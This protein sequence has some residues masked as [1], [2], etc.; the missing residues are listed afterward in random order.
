MTELVFQW[1]AGP[2]P[3]EVARA[4]HGA[5]AAHHASELSVRRLADPEPRGVRDDAVV[6]TEADARAVPEHERSGLAIDKREVSVI[7]LRT[8][9]DPS[10]H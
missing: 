10:L 3:P 5:D 1:L 9:L 6:H 4:L 2:V 8:P 7:L